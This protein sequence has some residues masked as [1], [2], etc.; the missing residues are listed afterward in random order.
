M[1]LINTSDPSVQPSVVM[2]VYGEGGVGKSTFTSTA[3]A[4]IMADCEGGSKYFGLR[5]ISMDVAMIEKWSEMKEF[6][7]EA[8]KPKYETIIIDPIGE[9]ME[10]LNKYMVALG[11]PKLVQKDGSPT[12]SGW[13]WLKKTMRN[14]IKVLRDCGKHV[15]I[16][17]HLDERN[18]EER[19]IKRPMI[20]TKLSQ[21]L[22]NIVDVVGYMST[23]RVDGEVVKRYIL[24]DPEDDKYVAKD[25]TGQLG[26]Y[27][28]P[29][30]TKI[31][32]A[33]Q[34]T[35]TFAWS[36]PKKET[37]TK[38]DKKDKKVA[39]KKVEEKN[40]K[41]EIKEDAVKKAKKK[42]NQAKDDK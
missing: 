23:R 34:G 12:M 19:M 24:I 21:E 32:Q 15:I 5:G 16:V 29:D 11:D 35:E 38:A 37:K 25:R 4:P 28:E 30:F 9:L 27:V 39:E 10:K 14:L 6:M 42:L 7:Q 22:V 3:P 36:K 8:R 13:G 40:E 41:E 31:V 1:K 18:D 2:M 17:A 26:R 33:C 20:P